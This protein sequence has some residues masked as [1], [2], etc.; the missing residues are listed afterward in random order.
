MGLVNVSYVLSCLRGFFYDKFGEE[1]K[2]IFWGGI[3]M[4]IIFNN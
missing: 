1:G 4:E 3:S 2:Y